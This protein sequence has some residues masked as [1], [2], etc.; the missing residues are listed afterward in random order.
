M[1]AKRLIVEFT[2]DCT[3]EERIYNYV[4]WDSA[5]RQISKLIEDD[6]WSGIDN[7]MGYDWWFEDDEVES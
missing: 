4:D 1:M 6:Y 5:L 2:G 3:E 7:P